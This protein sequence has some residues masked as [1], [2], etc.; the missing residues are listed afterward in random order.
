VTYIVVTGQQVYSIF[1]IRAIYLYDT[2]NLAVFQFACKHVSCRID[3]LEVKFVGC[4]LKAVQSINS[5]T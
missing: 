1:R 5:A 2:E 4:G 3:L